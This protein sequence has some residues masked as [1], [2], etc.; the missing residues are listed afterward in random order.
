METLAIDNALQEKASQI[1]KVWGLR[2]QE[3][4]R[5]FLKKL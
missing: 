4:Y 2:H 1:L 3:P 5:G